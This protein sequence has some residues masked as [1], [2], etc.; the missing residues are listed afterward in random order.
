MYTKFPEASVLC[1]QSGRYALHLVAQYSESLELL[2]DIL[3][4][5][6]KIT[7]IVTSVISASL[8]LP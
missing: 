1:D 8:G 3:Q 4:I 2:Q 5:D 6:Q 7:K